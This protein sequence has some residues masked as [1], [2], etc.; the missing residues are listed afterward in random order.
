M[1]VNKLACCVCFRTEEDEML[2]Y[3][4]Y[5]KKGRNPKKKLNVLTSLQ[6]K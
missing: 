3:R 6:E 2:D 5:Q 1:C 4:I